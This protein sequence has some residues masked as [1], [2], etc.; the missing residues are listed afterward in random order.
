MHNPKCDE[1]D[2][3]WVLHA[4]DERVENLE[5]VTTKAFNRM[6]LVHAKPEWISI[7]TCEL[8]KMDI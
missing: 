3:L 2:H 6:G 1:E 8:A 5:L 4:K 7:H